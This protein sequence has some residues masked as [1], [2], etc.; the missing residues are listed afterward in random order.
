MNCKKDFMET[1]G[2]IFMIGG[3]YNAENFE[4]IS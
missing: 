3:T 4:K 1:Q 2:R